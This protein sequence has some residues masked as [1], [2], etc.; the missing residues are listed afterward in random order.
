M[1]MT[2]ASR[3]YACVHTG[4]STA[5]ILA[6]VQSALA[7]AAVPEYLARDLRVLGRT[8]G[9]APIDP[10]EIVLME[11]SPGAPGPGR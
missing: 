1:T 4:Q 8:E 3:P 11:R 6:C 5:A 2:R 10:V 7:I 9:L